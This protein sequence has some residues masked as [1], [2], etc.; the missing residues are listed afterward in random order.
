MKHYNVNC[1]IYNITKLL[2][3][4]TLLFFSPYTITG[5]LM[6]LGGWQGSFLKLV[7]DHQLLLLQLQKILICYNVISLGHL[8][9]RFFLCNFLVNHLLLGFFT[10]M[11]W[12]WTQLLF[13]RKFFGRLSD[14]CQH[15]GFWMITLDLDKFR[16]L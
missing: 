14:S 13:W 1:I 3:T 11:Q 15:F 9:C 6:T 10:K 5:R 2:S 4:I 16:R 12:S 7:L 8:T